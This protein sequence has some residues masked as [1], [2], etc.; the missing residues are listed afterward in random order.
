M[1]ML[2]PGCQR[3]PESFRR[4]SSYEGTTS[5]GSGLNADALANTVVGGTYLTESSFGFLAHHSGLLRALRVYFVWSSIRPGY[6][7]GSGGSLLI[8][9]ESDD[10]RG[11]HHPSGNTVASILEPDPLNNGMFP[12]LTFPSPAQID[13]GTTYHIVFTNVDPDPANNYVSVNSLWMQSGLVPRQPT[14]NDADWFQLMRDSSNHGM[15]VPR[16]YG[17]GQSFTP[18][19]EL[20][21]ADGS[22]D[23]VGYMEV[24]VGNPKVVSGTLGVRELFTAGGRNRKVS[25]VSVRLRRLSGSDSLR[26]QLQEAAGATIAVS[27][28]PASAIP[29]TY[30]WVTFSCPSV[31]TLSAGTRYALVLNCAATSSYDLFP[32]RKGSTPPRFQAGTFFPDGYA[33]FTSG[34]LWTG[35]DQ[36]GQADRHDGDL[37]FYF[38]EVPD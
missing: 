18:I 17:T 19:L 24:W 25:A 22:S 20:D 27:G 14:I 13:S 29:L 9:L 4:Q 12:L 37:Q 34:G 21:Y 28:F 23:G 32:I 15:W 10:A 33:Q 16:E 31:T 11:G 8:R 1:S 36:W 30:T 5:Y 3:G 6:N 7:A 38:A 26:I 2:F 35:W